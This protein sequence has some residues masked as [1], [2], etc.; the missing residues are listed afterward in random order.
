MTAQP[1]SRGDYVADQILPLVTVSETHDGLAVGRF[2]GSCF[3]IGRT[4]HAITA[5]HVLDGVAD[6]VAVLVFQEEREKGGRLGWEARGVGAW[7]PHHVED[8][9]VLRIEDISW[10]TFLQLGDKH[11]TQGFRYR[12]L[13]YPA[14]VAHELIEGHAV[15]FRPNLVYVEGYIRRR[16]SGIPV[17]AIRG[18]HLFE[19]STAAG[20]GASGSPLIDVSPGERWDVV[21]VYVGQR[22]TEGED[23]VRLGYAA[24]ADAFRE[25]TPDLLA[26][27]TVLDDSRS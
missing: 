5:A 27:R 20:L 23:P 21:G 14:D 6:R 12:Q 26:G 11:V 22:V 3:R 8:V 15:R 25:W 18:E 7:E 16:M 13:A 17:P 2:L 10:R 24:R 1:P 19:V 9:A 4:G